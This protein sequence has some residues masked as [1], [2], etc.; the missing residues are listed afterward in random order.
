MSKSE[1]LYDWRF[2]ADQFV[3]A[4]IPLRLTAINFF[5]L[6]PCDHGHY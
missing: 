2:A 6:K 5:Q 1:L 3:L 4:L